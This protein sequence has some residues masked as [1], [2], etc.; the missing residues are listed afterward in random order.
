VMELDIRTGVDP[1][2]L[3]RRIS[4]DDL[5]EALRNAGVH[6]KDLEP[7]SELCRGV[8]QTVGCIGPQRYC[9]QCLYRLLTG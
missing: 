7:S 6:S 4:T 1:V 5:V 9:A 3:G 2:D 8:T